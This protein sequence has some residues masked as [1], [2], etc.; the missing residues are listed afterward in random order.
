MLIPTVRPAVRVCDLYGTVDKNVL[1]KY[2]KQ[3]Y[4]WTGS[5]S[6]AIYLAIKASGAKK[7][8]IP[9]FTCSIVA[10]T[11]RKT[12][13]RPQFYDAGIVPTLADVRN[14]LKSKPDL[15]IIAYNFGLVPDEL[16]KILDLCKRQKVQVLEDCAHAFGF[17]QNADFTIYSA[18]IAKSLSHYG[19]FLVSKRKLDLLSLSDVP[20]ISEVKFML[21]SVGAQI[22]F[23]K[24]IYSFYNTFVN[25]YIEKYPT[26]K[27]YSISSFAKK[28]ILRQLKRFDHIQLRRTTNF[29]LAKKLK[30]VV[31]TKKRSD[32]YLVLQSNHRNKLSKY[33]RSRSIEFVPTKSFHNLGGPLFKKAAI[34]EKE[35]L[36]FSLYRSKNDM[37]V[38]ID[39]IKTIEKRL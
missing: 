28:V 38:V 26:A 39:A 6:A 35:H 15:I 2:F 22:V 3:N 19:G 27:I 23:N 13:I 25:R 10:D 37:E 18:G 12:G 16:D 8:A 20:L 17:G 21:Q 4:S 5:G 36:A 7:V 33:L 9:A 29:E 24:H 1:P 34:A 14:A 11:V 30:H 32:L 31:K